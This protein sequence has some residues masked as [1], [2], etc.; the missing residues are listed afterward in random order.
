MRKTQAGDSPETGYVWPWKQVCCDAEPVAVQGVQF[1]SLVREPSS[2]R[3]V[4]PLPSRRRVLAYLAAGGAAIVQPRLARAAVSG[5]VQP[6]TLT[7]G[8][9][10]NA[11][12]VIE[13][14]RSLASAPFQP[15]STELP[16]SLTDLDYVQYRDIYFKA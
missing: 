4:L 15:L 11:D 14:A 16:P 5:T 9:P 2:M 10:F 7:A 12:S 6:P 8:Q 1:G 3:P 13:M